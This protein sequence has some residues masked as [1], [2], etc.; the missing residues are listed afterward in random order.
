MQL[1][2]SCG[3]CC[4]H[5]EMELSESD[6]LRIEQNNPYKWQRTEF[7]I[8]Q[9]QMWRLK[10]EKDHCVF[11]DPSQKM[12]LIY[13][14]RPTGCQFYPMI[15]D[16]EANRC[17]LDE[18]CPHRQAFYPYKIDFQAHCKKLKVWVRTELFASQ[19]EE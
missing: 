7:A 4:L 19:E 9:D 17:V 10:N 16:P 6:L 3:L 11:F 5:T 18:E 1:C 8:H 13:S 2:R 15:Y 14:H 12:C